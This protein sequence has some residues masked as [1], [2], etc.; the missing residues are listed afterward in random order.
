[1]TRSRLATLLAL[2]SLLSACLEPGTPRSLRP[3]LPGQ[4]SGVVFLDEDGDGRLSAGEPGIADVTVSNGRDVTRSDRAG[5]YRLPVSDD[6]ILFVVQPRNYRVPVDANGVPRFYYL[7]KPA[8]SPTN[9]RY[10][11][12]APTGPLPRQVDFALLRSEVG[13]RFQALLLGDPQTRTLQDVAYLARDIVA[14]LVG[15]SASFALALG[16][17]VY[18]DLSVFEPLARTLGQIAVPW[19]PVIGNHDINYLATHDTYSDESF[20]RLFGPTNY[21]FQVGRV[22]FIVLD[23]DVYQGWI[24]ADE[25][26]GGYRA[27]FGD[28]ELTFLERYLEL[29][30][31]DEL[32]VVVTHI[33]LATPEDRRSAGS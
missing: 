31:R 2:A 3:G 5:Y 33:P 4:A 8:G 28:D 24:E 21:A 20:E 23:S 10:P 12:V 26:P 15:T 18:D 16:D 6:T 32:V 27:A 25:M 1:M 7:H 17:L 30:P 13:D 11:G 29:V 14:P 22:H 19:W 9:L